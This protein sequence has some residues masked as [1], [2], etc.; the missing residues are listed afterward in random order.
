[1]RNSRIIRSDMAAQGQ[2]FEKILEASWDTRSNEV[3]AE[4][5]WEQFIS[6]FQYEEQEIEKLHHAECG[7]YCPA[8]REHTGYKWWSEKN[9]EEGCACGYEEYCATCAYEDEDGYLSP[10]EIRWMEIENLLQ[11]QD[12]ERL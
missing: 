4:M 5:E 7:Q 11:D 3:I 2:N 10:Q 9:E 12:M 6:K 1:M 8:C